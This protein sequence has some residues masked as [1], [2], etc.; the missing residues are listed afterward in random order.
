[1]AT[2]IKNKPRR[3]KRKTRLTT[4]AIVRIAGL[5]SGEKA[6]KKAKTTKDDNKGF[7]PKRILLQVDS[8]EIELQNFSIPE[9]IPER[10]GKIVSASETGSM[11]FLVRE[12]KDLNMLKTWLVSRT[13]KPCKLRMFSSKTAPEPSLEMSF[14]I[15]ITSLYSGSI[16]IE[17]SEPLLFV[18][19]F[20]ITD[21]IL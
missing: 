5:V 20:K 6:V 3:R 19:L 7:L 14:E 18:A 2:P 10:T 4:A 21:F 8:E 13:A 12:S 11:G 17:Y 1:M 15:E 9:L 16:N